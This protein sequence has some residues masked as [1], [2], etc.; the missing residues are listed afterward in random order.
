MAPEWLINAQVMRIHQ[1]FR[2]RYYR[3]LARQEAAAAAA[4]GEQ[5]GASST[6]ELR[7]RK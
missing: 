7:K 1:G 2:A 5:E 3:R 4:G 6:R